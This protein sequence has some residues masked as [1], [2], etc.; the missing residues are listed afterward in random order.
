M[1]EAVVGALQRERGAI[2]RTVDGLSTE[3]TEHGAFNAKGSIHATRHRVA[4]SPSMHRYTVGNG[5][6]LDR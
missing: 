4:P 1:H 5:S 3:G 6:D 2:R